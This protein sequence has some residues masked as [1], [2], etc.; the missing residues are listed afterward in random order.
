LILSMVFLLFA[1]FPPPFWSESGVESSLE[2]TIVAI[3]IGCKDYSKPATL[4]VNRAALSD[5]WQKSARFALEWVAGL[6]AIHKDLPI[7][8][9]ADRRLVNDPKRLSCSLWPWI[10]PNIR[11]QLIL[12]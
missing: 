8:L 11:R 3:A 1:T 2:L 4:P 9:A 7:D 5:E 10:V 12:E 6:L